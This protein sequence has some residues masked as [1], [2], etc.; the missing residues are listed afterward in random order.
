M[1]LMSVHK[2]LPVKVSVSLSPSSERASDGSTRFAV[3][4]THTAAPPRR[5]QTRGARRRVGSARHRG[6][7]QVA[8]C[9]ETALSEVAEEGRTHPLFSVAVLHEAEDPILALAV[10]PRASAIPFSARTLCYRAPIRASKSS[11]PTCRQSRPVVQR[12]T[13]MARLPV[14]RWPTFPPRFARA[15]CCRDTEARPAAR[16][17]DGSPA[18]GA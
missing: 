10:T 2:K 3:C 1:I 13:C 6:Y 8:P 9:R 15:S 18:A 12:R 11:C 7:Q 14:M 16:V 4:T 17:L 5:R